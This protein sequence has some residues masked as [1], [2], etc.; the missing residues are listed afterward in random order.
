MSRPVEFW[1]AIPTANWIKKTTARYT[2]IHKYSQAAV[3]KKECIV[4]QNA[5]D[6]PFQII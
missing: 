5:R 2:T 4:K 6:N 1:N 3:A